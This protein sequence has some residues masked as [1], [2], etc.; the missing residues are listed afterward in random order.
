MELLN[1]DFDT[2]LDVSV[3]GGALVVTPVRDEE[4]KKS[5]EQAIRNTN[6]RY[7][8]ALRRLAE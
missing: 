6:G 3:D 5:F 2:P 4:R 7:G 8:R 1:I